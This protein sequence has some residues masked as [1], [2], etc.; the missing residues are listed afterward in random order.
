MRSMAGF[1][2]GRGRPV[3]NR[4]S[5][6]R[7]SRGFRACTASDP[8]RSRSIVPGT[9][10]LDQH[11]RGFHQPQAELDPLRLF[12]GSIESVLAPV[13]PHEEARLVAVI[14]RAPAAA[15]VAAVTRFQFVDNESRTRRGSACNKGPRACGDDAHPRRTVQLRLLE[16]FFSVDVGSGSIRRHLP[17]TGSSHY[18][19]MALVE[20]RTGE[21]RRMKAE[22][23]RSARGGMKDE[24]NAGCH[25][26]DC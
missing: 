18:K 8:G 9:K 12:E 2:A 5:S 16:N 10:I 22:G 4:K 14:W 17:Q 19:D 25:P 15:H 13:E 11:V 24:R 20:K 6:N 7:I 26:V 23:R 3:R 1:V 21:N